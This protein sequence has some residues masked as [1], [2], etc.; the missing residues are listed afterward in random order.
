MC[1]SVRSVAA[2]AD[3]IEDFFFGEFERK[4]IAFFSAESAEAAAVYADVRVVDMAVYDVVGRISV[5]PCPGM[6]SERT[7][8]VHVRAGKKPLTL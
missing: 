8:G 5:K 3:F 1:T 4:R 6:M 2:G 7:E